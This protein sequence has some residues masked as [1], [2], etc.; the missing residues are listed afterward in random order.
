MR[1]FIFVFSLMILSFLPGLALAG[2]GWALAQDG[3]TYCYKTDAKGNVS[4]D[5]SPIGWD[6]CHQFSKWGYGQDNRLYCYPTGSNGVL[7][8]GG[9]PIDGSACH[10]H[11]RWHSADN[12]GQA[13]FPA[14]SF[15]NMPD[16]LSAVDSSYCTK[17]TN[18]VKATAVRKS[19]MEFITSYTQPGTTSPDSDTYLHEMLAH[20]TAAHVGPEYFGK[21]RKMLKPKQAIIDLADKMFNHSTGELYSNYQLVLDQLGKKYF[22]GYEKNILAFYIADEPSGFGIT[23][24]SLE[25][26]IA[27]LKARFKGVPTYIVW[28]RFCFD[29]DPSLDATCGTAG[30]RGIPA[31]LDWIGFDWY[32]TGAPASDTV[33]FQRKTIDNVE[34]LK[35]LTHLPIILVPDGTDEYL[36]QYP[37]N[38]RDQILADRMKLYY[39]YAQS[40]SRIIG[41]DNYAWANHSESFQGNVRYVKGIREYPKARKLLESYADSVRHNAKF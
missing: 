22:D 16:G 10:V 13:C 3:V 5:A 31:G 24:Q 39:D 11:Y 8:P 37:E 33:D 18:P 26:V 32:L 19:P 29:N 38:Q 35:K 30:G 21:V 9:T 17:K 14:D 28:N 23:R 7:P 15:G 20:L 2:S 25:L 36:Q 34:R 6:S 4:D 41:L 12:G 1:R 40:E 27:A